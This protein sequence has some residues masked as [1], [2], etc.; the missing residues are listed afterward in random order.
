[1]KS[2]IQLVSGV[3]VVFGLLLLGY[4]SYSTAID[5]L[6]V[7]DVTLLEKSTARDKNGELVHLF[8]LEVNDETEAVMP[9]SNASYADHE[10]GDT[11]WYW[12]RDIDA[13]LGKEYRE[14]R[15][16][17]VLWVACILPIIF[18]AAFIIINDT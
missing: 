11:I 3:A 17:S 7:S 12:K 10:V 15:F 4:N 8:K 16:E 5:F 13:D 1:M 9:V 6:Q 2:I 18:L 14:W